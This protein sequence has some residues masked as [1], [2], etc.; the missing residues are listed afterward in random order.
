VLAL[1]DEALAARLE[2]WRAARTAEVAER[3]ADEATER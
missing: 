2:A 3:P 1:A